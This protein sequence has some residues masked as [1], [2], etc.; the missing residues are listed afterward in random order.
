M[1]LSGQVPPS[2]LIVVFDWRLMRGG[3]LLLGAV[4]AE[5]DVA[6]VDLSLGLR[7]RGARRQ[8]GQRQRGDGGRQNQGVVAGRGM[9]ALLTA[10]RIASP[11]RFQALGHGKR[12]GRGVAFWCAMVGDVR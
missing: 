8:R 4:G 10:L 2:S 9:A 5:L 1:K 7:V 6:D 12:R 11:P 3:H